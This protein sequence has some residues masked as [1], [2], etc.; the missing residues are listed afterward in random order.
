[1]LDPEWIKLSLDE[2]SVFSSM[3]REPF[4]SYSYCDPDEIIEVVEALPCRSDDENSRHFYSTKK[5]TEAQRVKE[6][7]RS[8]LSI[9]EQRWIGTQAPRL[10]RLLSL[11]PCWATPPLGPTTGQGDP[12]TQ[13]LPLPHWRQTAKVFKPALVHRAL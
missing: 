12:H 1:L 10:Q 7:A 5:E 2:A 3:K 8:P 11:N 9:K 6:Q 13:S 4:P